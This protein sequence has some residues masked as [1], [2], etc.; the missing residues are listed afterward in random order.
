[1]A[2]GDGLV[3]MT[4]TSIAHSGTS[5]TINADGGVDFTAVS[6]L[7]LNGVFTSDY[8]NYFLVWG[9]IT[10]TSALIN[11]RLRVAG[12]DATG[13]NYTHQILQAQGTTVTGDRISSASDWRLMSMTNVQVNGMVM[14]CYGPFLAQP[15]AYRT[16]TIRS[17]NDATIDDY[18]GTHS[19]STAYDGFTVATSSMSGNVHVF[20]Y[21]E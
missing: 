7:T 4:P 8:D 21:E 14:H 12:T 20:G 10:G 18:A 2:A 3:S 5:A 1:M 13:S 15:T 17:L 19:L 9:S 6:S 11:M 16:V